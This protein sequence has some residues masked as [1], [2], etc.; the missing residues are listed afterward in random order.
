MISKTYIAHLA[1]C[2][3]LCDRDCSSSCTQVSGQ[4]SGEVASARLALLDTTAECDEPPTGKRQVTLAMAGSGQA[5][6]PPRWQVQLAVDTC[7]VAKRAVPAGVVDQVAQL[8]QT[9]TRLS[10][11]LAGHQG[12]VATVANFVRA[13]YRT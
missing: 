8:P 7:H 5:L 10:F 12:E 1:N 2:S 3:V 9:S 4:G 13:G 11:W 6:L